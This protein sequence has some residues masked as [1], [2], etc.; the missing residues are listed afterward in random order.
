MPHD[1]HHIDPDAGD[2]RV[3]A[4]IAVNMGLTVAQIV[5]GIFSGSLALIADALHNFSDAENHI[6]VER[7]AEDGGGVLTHVVQHGFPMAQQDGYLNSEWLKF[8]ATHITNT[9][10][11]VTMPPWNQ[12][13]IHWNTGPPYLATVRE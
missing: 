8:N 9:K 13:A 1:H 12:G 6:F 10:D 7:R 2:R 11:H 3:F 4:A 5:G